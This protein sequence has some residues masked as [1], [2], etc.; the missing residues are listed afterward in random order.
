MKTE[1][2]KLM[3][4]EFLDGELPK[5]K[6]NLLFTALGQNEEAREYFKQVNSI[7]ALVNGSL[8]EYPFALDEKIYG[9]IN[10]TERGLNIF[11][12]RNFFTY[13]LS[14]LL[15]IALTA[16]YFL[17]D[18]YSYQKEQLDVVNQRL[19]RQNELMELI[20][21]TQLPQITVKP[22]YPSHFKEIIIHS[23][24]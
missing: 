4:D 2:I 3:I 21:T 14:V 6:E 7:K 15:V 9:G 11:T 13:A 10:K 12:K 1:E 23:N 19:E 5:N 18:Q 8:E 24:L 20:I 17:F 22:V 16:G